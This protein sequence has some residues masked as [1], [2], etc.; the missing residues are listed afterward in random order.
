MKKI[1]EKIFIESEKRKK[2]LQQKFAIFV[3]F[4]LNV[5]L[6]WNLQ[7]RKVFCCLKFHLKKWLKRENPVKGKNWGLI[8]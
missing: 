1:K 6:L 7:K 4:K 8:I 2:C 5:Q 3:K